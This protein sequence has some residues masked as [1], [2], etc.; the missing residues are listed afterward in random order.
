VKHW[1]NHS[2]PITISTLFLAEG[3][4]DIVL[5]EQALLNLDDRASDQQAVSLFLTWFRLDVSSPTY[6]WVLYGKVSPKD[7]KMLDAV[8]RT[9]EEVQTMLVTAKF[10]A[11]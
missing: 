6:Q 7:Y 8:Y 1:T 2:S 5:R 11:D 9:R 4:D 3:Y 10:I